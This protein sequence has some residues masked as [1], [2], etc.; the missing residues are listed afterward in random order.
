[1]K[2]NFKE[3]SEVILKV[4]ASMD[5]AKQGTGNKPE[6]TGHSQDGRPLWLC[7]EN[8]VFVMRDMIP[9]TTYH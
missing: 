5:E 9:F 2:Y 8:T 7:S 1:M 4:R 3:G 6:S